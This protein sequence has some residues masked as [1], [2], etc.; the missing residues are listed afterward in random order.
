M[1]ASVVPENDSQKISSQLDE[2]QLLSLKHFMSEINDFPL[3][4]NDFLV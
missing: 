1:R 2:F 3:D 4:F